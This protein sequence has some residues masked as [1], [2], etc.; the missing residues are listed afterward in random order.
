MFIGFG[1]AGCNSDVDEQWQHQVC[2]S[3]RWAGPCH[4]SIP[5]R[6]KFI[7]IYLATLR[8]TAGEA[9][10]FKSKGH[11]SWRSWLLQGGFLS[12]WLHE[13]FDRARQDNIHCQFAGQKDWISKSCWRFAVVRPDKGGG[14]LQGENQPWFRWFQDWACSMFCPLLDLLGMM[15]GWWLIAVS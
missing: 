9:E 3:S 13:I 15:I 5:N 11:V 8:T 7:E 4:L 14:H 10:L 12:K 2:H 6:S 1:L